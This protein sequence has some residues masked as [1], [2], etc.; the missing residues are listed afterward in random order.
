[1][2]PEH[3]EIHG[4]FENYKVCK[5]LLFKMLKK[6]PPK[7]IKNKKYLKTSIVNFDDQNADYFLKINADKKIAISLNSE[8]DMA[9]IKLMDL[10]LLKPT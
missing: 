4:G 5:G 10:E 9:K 8:L 6:H 1:L 2:Q 3:L 7:Y